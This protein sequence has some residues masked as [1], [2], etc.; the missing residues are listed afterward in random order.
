V[1]K[2]LV[3]LS[4]LVWWPLSLHGDGVVRFDLVTGEGFVPKSVIQDAFAL[5]NGQLKRVSGLTFAFAE[6]DTVVVNCKNGRT[7]DAFVEFGS[8]VGSALAYTKGQFVGF[9]LT[10]FVD[11]EW[12][13]D[14]P[15]ADAFCAGGTFG[16]IT[17]RRFTLSAVFGDESVVIL[18]GGITP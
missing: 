18:G 15:P 8:N 2:L 7:F 5:S 9:D 17:D 16:Q 11:P 13:K 3:V 4:L 6:K 10:G 1:S 12:V 14:P